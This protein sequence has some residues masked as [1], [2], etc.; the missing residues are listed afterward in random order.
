[1]ATP[2]PTIK[3]VQA[4]LRDC[5]HCQARTLHV[6][7][8]TTDPGKPAVCLQCVADGGTCCSLAAY[9]RWK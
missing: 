1:M 7:P 4:Q 5:P 2:T 9:N 6:V 8:R 3:K